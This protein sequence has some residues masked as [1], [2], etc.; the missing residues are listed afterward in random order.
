MRNMSFSLWLGARVLRETLTRCGSTCNNAPWSVYFYISDC[1]I[2]RTA[3]TLIS[4]S[5][6]YV[7]YSQCAPWCILGTVGP[8]DLE[9]AEVVVQQLQSFLIIAGLWLRLTGS[10]N[11]SEK[12]TPPSECL[13]KAPVFP[14]LCFSIFSLEIYICIWKRLF[15]R[16]LISKWATIFCIHMTVCIKSPLRFC[17]DAKGIYCH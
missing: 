9:T 6:V 2:E 11:V 3:Q 5:A 1:N 7:G 8:E 10:W 16:W 13:L 4:Q 12:L 15:R 17:A 14:E